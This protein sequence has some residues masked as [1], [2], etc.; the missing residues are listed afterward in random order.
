MPGSYVLKGSSKPEESLKSKQQENQSNKD[1]LLTPN[2][3]NG[4]FESSYY[5]TLFDGIRK[6]RGVSL[7]S[8]LKKVLVT[9]II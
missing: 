3:K 7:Y 4:F 2:R 6:S 5:P 9:R 1:K 8:N